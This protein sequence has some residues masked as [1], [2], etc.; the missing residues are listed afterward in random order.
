MDVL[1]RAR[2]RTNLLG[3]MDGYP[4]LL[5]IN[6]YTIV[7]PPVIV[8]HGGQMM[9]REITC[10]L[11]LLYPNTRNAG[12]CYQTPWIPPSLTCQLSQLKVVR[13][14]QYRVVA[15]PTYKL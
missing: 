5:I 4:Q 14:M 1:P 7:T 10:G 8:D 9:A 11:T 15:R 6:P 2:K 13:A 3:G 12:Q